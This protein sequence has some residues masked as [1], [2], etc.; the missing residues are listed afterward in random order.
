MQSVQTLLVA[1]IFANQSPENMTLQQKPLVSKNNN[2]EVRYNRALLIWF[3]CF[4]VLQYLTVYVEIRLKEQSKSI[5][6]SFKMYWC[7]FLET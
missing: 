6:Y 5:S 3:Q 1:T 4:L 7:T 2:L